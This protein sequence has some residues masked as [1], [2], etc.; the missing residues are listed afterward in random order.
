MYLKRNKELE[1]ISLYT[2]DY[3]KQFYL[4]EI[5]M[6]AKIP[7]KTAQN[8]LSYLE[9]AK[10]LKATTKGK[11]KYF[12]LNVDNAQTKLYI[13]QAE[14]YKTMV[15][16]DQYPLLKAFLKEVSVNSTIIVFGSFAR[17]IAGKES[18]IDLLIISKEPSKLPLHLLS[19]RTHK[20]ELSES[21]FQES[22]KKQE[23]L[24]KEIEENHIIL[25]N[26]SF[27]VNIMWNYYGK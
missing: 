22:I 14:I 11:H 24:I 16:L 20:I 13:I 25:N 21:S 15:F 1:I 2:A 18:D 4:R 10:I 6:L 23:T 7:L 9:E 27:Y 3:H 17:S 26:H 8:V 12:R 5:S 19:Y